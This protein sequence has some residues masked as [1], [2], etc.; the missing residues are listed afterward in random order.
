MN[1][2]KRNENENGRDIPQRRQL[3]KN[4]KKTR[5]GQNISANSK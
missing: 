2:K 4:K 1:G 3:G 5:N